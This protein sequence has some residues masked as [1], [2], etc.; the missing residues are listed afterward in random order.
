MRDVGS[1]KPYLTFDLDLGTRT[2]GASIF[3]PKFEV[4]GSIFHF[5]KNLRGWLITP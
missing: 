5:F 3:A 2:S 4:V 1:E